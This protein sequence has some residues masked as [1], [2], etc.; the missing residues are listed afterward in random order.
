MKSGQHF[1]I[2]DYFQDWLISDD[3]FDPNVQF[4]VTWNRNQKNHLD[5]NWLIVHVITNN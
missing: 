2:V 3:V 5:S 4:T 1:F